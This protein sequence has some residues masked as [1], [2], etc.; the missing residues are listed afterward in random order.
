MDSE[1]RPAD[2]PSRVQNVNDIHA[3]HWQDRVVKRRAGATTCATLWPPWR[4]LRYLIP[5][6]GKIHRVMVYL[7]RQKLQTKGI[8][9]DDVTNA[10]NSTNQILP[11]GEL[12]LAPTTGTSRVTLRFPRQTMMEVR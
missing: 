10:I 5:F 8:T 11:A 9:L 2:F 7:D 6:G 3:L 12:K 4:E 1:R